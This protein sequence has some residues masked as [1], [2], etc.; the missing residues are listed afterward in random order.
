MRVTSL[1]MGR[2]RLQAG[3]EPSSAM[4]GPSGQR[5]WRLSRHLSLGARLRLLTMGAVVLTTVLVTGLAMQR[6]MANAEARL[7]R[8]G[9]L[10]AR[11]LAE[12]ALFAL[13][14][15]DRQQL[16]EAIEGLRADP[17]IALVRFGQADGTVLHED[18]LD[19]TVQAPAW[20]PVPLNEAAAD[21]RIWHT[22]RGLSG[23]IM[24]TLQI[25]LTD[26]N[27][28]LP[29]QVQ[30]ENT[31]RRAGSY[32]ELGLT[33]SHVWD[34]QL[35]FLEDAALVGIA[36]L[37]A[38]VITASVVVRRI[39]RPVNRL[40]AA[41]GQ[42][43]A[44]DLTVTIAS[45]AQDEIGV[46]TRAFSAMVERLRTYQAEL[47]SH[48]DDLETKVEQRTA[49]LEAS[50]REAQEYARQAD[51]A[52]RA[53][54]QF[55]A[56]MSH[57]IRTPMNG[58]IGM[59]ELLRNTSLSVQQRRHT[60]TLLASAEALLDLLNGIL[61]FSKIEA[62]KLELEAA[63]FHLRDAVESVCE[64]LAQRAH[65]AGLELVCDIDPDASRTVVGDPGR[66]R[67]V[68][69][70]LVGNAV[71]FTLRGEVSVRVRTVAQ[72]EATAT[73]RVEVQDT[74]VGIEPDALRRL[75]QPFVQADEST[76][77]K[78]GGTGLGLAISRQ[79]VE[80]MGGEM[81]V[82][83]QPGVG[84]RFWFTVRLQLHSAADSLP[85]A[86]MPRLAGMHV[87]VV[88]DHPTNREVLVQMLRRLRANVEGVPDPAAAL[89][90]VL[91][92]ARDG[93]PFA[94]A[95][96]DMLMPEMDGVEL[97][98]AMRRDSALRGL[99]IVLL[100]STVV[101]LD[102][103]DDVLDGRLTKP[104]RQ[105]ELLEVIADAFSDRRE[106]PGSGPLP[107]ADDVGFPAG[108]TLLVV[109][110][111]TVNR[112]VIA[113]LLEGFDL[114]IVEAADGA[115]ALQRLTE[116][117]VDLVLMDCQM[118]VLDGYAATGEIR[119]RQVACPRGR[120]LPVVALT[121]SALKGERERCL[122]AGMDDYLAKPVRSSD[123]LSTLRR[124]LGTSGPR[125]TRVISDAEEHNPDVAGQPALDPVVI[126]GLQGAAGRG[127]P[128][129][130]RRLAPLYLT[131]TA[132]NVTNLLAALDAG[133]TGE[134]ARLAH[135][136]KS[137]STMLGAVRLAELLRAIETAG[138]DN[139]LDDARRNAAQLSAEFERVQIAIGRMLNEP[140]C[141]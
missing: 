32:V 84:S 35:Q 79:L 122:A 128:D 75:F 127:R 29:G 96:V 11:V 4:R 72:D 124:W 17:D 10:L 121:A 114:Q 31:G 6:A 109:D 59:V 43:A 91:G 117:P 98:R 129:L 104:V 112:A 7:T 73:L 48:R 64:L 137:S 133:N 99:R 23:L 125:A 74:G 90:R 28:F 15:R 89:R 119:R 92:A 100:T 9:E 16:H 87:L 107:A 34:D 111:N 131:E 80:L 120:R 19:P 61:D 123:L 82:E 108:S 47:L 26:A 50:M 49:E 65:D 86:P 40:V 68:L 8:K 30:D 62:G 33:R 81:G 135:M 67:Q 95:L 118:P 134:A 105:A 130:F 20:K 55:L 52:N 13:Y 42:V 5:P 88:D 41:T 14:T 27:G 97:A 22:A 77:R 139:D 36:V 132:P 53:K 93:Q 138:K 1:V 83:S 71:K 44:G 103:S 69:L 141:A 58:V 126:G 45:D 78:Y 25:D 136:L 113:G 116:T 39:L 63:P 85:P 46:L 102:T 2:E 54:S 106:D 66:L 94:L 60:D 51:Q 76:T 3:T 110:D 18:V 12:N 115:E 24:I 70:N 37:V 57:E 21:L 56:N 38:G 101:P 140:R